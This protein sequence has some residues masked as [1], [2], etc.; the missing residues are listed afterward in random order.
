MT[1]SAKGLKGFLI[2]GMGGLMFRVYDPNEEEGFVDYDIWHHDLEI[3][4]IDDDSVIRDDK[5]IDYSNQT[6]GYKDE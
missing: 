3:Q 4:I 6:L 2:H 1:K 5:A